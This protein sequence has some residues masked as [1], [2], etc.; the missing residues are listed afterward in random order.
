MPGILVTRV[1]T[2]GV[3][4]SRPSPLPPIRP[5]P[6]PRSSPG[7]ICPE[8]SYTT[9][10]QICTLTAD[11]PARRA[12]SLAAQTRSRTSSAVRTRVC[13]IIWRAHGERR[14]AAGGGGSDER[15][16]IYRVLHSAVTSRRGTPCLL[17]VCGSPIAPTPV[18]LQYAFSL[19]TPWTFAPLA[20]TG[21]R[22]ITDTC[23]MKVSILRKKN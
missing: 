4:D 22:K 6:P 13:S 15:L 21:R 11:N 1:N 9:H 20:D 16:N 17:Y 7:L 10:E 8:T 23:S 19:R 18:S 14:R 3:A 5:P 12:R 2:S